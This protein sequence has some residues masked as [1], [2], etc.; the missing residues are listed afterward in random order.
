MYDLCQGLF[1]FGN[2][3]ANQD[4]GT[5]KQMETET[6]KQTNEKRQQK[7]WRHRRNMAWTKVIDL[8]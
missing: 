2:V 8:D 5:G 1:G 7:K 6:V 4:L 3:D